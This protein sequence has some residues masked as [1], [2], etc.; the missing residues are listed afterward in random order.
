MVMLGDASPAFVAKL[1]PVDAEITTRSRYFRVQ[2]PS[3]LEQQRI[4]I[5]E[6][7]PLPPVLLPIVADYV[8]TTA[9]DMRTHGLRVEAT[10]SNPMAGA[11]E[12]ALVP[13]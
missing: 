10:T 8:A 3:Y 13:L 11:D 9:E 4:S 12:D 7:C 2:L 6:H 1:S 5:F